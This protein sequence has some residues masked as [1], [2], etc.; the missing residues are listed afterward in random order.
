MQ[1]TT[2]TIRQYWSTCGSRCSDA[3]ESC[4]TCQ[5]QFLARHSPPAYLARNSLTLLDI[6][7]N[8]LG[9]GSLARSFNDRARAEN[10]FILWHSSYPLLF[11]FLTA[12]DANAVDSSKCPFINFFV[13]CG[14]CNRSPSEGLPL[15]S[16]LPTHSESNSSHCRTVFSTFLLNITILRLSASFLSPD[17]TAILSSKTRLLSLF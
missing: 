12:K 2:G 17:N 6:C 3:H 7:Q 11:L 8:E 5:D 9:P 1:Q 13:C 4:R 16:T 10:E 15:S 14:R